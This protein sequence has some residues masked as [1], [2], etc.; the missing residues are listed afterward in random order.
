MN[1]TAPAL[2]TTP[3]QSLGKLLERAVLRLAEHL[4]RSAEERRRRRLAR[5]ALSVLQEMDGRVLRDL[6][7]DRSELPSIALNPADSTRRRLS[8]FG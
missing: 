1:T 6:G 5:A 4:R 8:S 7:L 3:L 2:G